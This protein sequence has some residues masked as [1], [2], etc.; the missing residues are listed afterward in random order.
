MPA[1]A[2]PIITEHRSEK[3]CT[4]QVVDGYNAPVTAGNFVDIARRGFY[5]G[6]TIQRADGFIVQTGDPDGPVG[7]L[8]CS[9]G[10]QGP[11]CCPGQSIP[12]V[13]YRALKGLRFAMVGPRCSCLRAHAGRQAGMRSCSRRRR[14]G[15]PKEDVL[16]QETSVSETVRCGVQATGFVDEKTGQNRTVPF[17]LMVVGDKV[18]RRVSHSAGWCCRVGEAA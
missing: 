17:E 9:I 4:C 15:S 6:L 10:R 1:V 13:L 14:L 16:P 2:L 8:L 7:I 12:M 18:R 11:C 3:V 5:D